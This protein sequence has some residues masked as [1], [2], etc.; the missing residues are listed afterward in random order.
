MKTN[1]TLF[2]CLLLLAACSASMAQTQT[3]PSDESNPH[4]WVSY[5]SE[6]GKFK[7]KF[8]AKP[9]ESSEVQEGEGGPSNVYLAEYKGLLLYVTT[10][11][12]SASHITDAK[13]YLKNVGN[14]W[15]DANSLHNIHV[16]KDE[17]ISFKNNPGRFVVVETQMQVVRA[18]WIVVGN[19]IYYQFVLAPKR[20]NAPASENGYEKLAT[21]FFDSFELTH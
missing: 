17:E 7:I 13:L 5:V 19:R 10:Y 15:L 20:Y 12:N 11:G 1:C 21:A 4:K 18:R 6:A 8:P 3:D 9:T 2:V 14:A 16:L